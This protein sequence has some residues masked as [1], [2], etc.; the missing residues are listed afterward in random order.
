M[1]LLS[2]NI[3]EQHRYAFEALTSGRCY[4]SGLE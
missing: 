2:T 4:N 1:F 3:T